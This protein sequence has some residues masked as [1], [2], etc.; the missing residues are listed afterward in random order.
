MTI[1]PEI[2]NNFPQN[3]DNHNNNK[4]ISRNKQNNYNNNK[5]NNMG[6]QHFLLNKTY[7]NDTN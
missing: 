4:S 2:N 7:K 3:N 6:H 1:S 5:T